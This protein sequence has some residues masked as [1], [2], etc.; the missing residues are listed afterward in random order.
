MFCN[1][2]LQEGGK[3]H[4]ILSKTI[5]FCFPYFS[6]SGG[7]RKGQIL[8]KHFKIELTYLMCVCIWEITTPANMSPVS[9]KPLII[10]FISRAFSNPN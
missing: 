6:P 2:C 9:M 8:K 10:K 5:V 1:E 3:M 4:K 7:I